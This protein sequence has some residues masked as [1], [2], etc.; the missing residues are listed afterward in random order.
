MASPAI[1]QAGPLALVE[2]ASKIFSA[3]AARKLRNTSGLPSC[4]H[5]LRP[6]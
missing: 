2:A 6:A 1:Q 3:F 5:S 4:A